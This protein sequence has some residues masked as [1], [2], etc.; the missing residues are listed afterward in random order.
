MLVNQGEKSNEKYSLVN[1]G[2]NKKRTWLEKIFLL[3]LDFRR[4]YNLVNYA[5]LGNWNIL[6]DFVTLRNFLK[7]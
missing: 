4:K 2:R 7:I 1:C 5:F 3:W 6:K